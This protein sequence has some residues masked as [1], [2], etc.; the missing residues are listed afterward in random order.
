[1][2]DDDLVFQLR[3]W[4]TAQMARFAANDDGPSAGDHILQ[5]NIDLAP[6]TIARAKRRI[7]G[8]DG[9]SRRRFMAQK[10]STETLKMS[11]IPAWAVDPVPCHNDAGSPTTISAS[12]ASADVGI[13]DD[14]RWIDRAVSQMSRQHPVRAMVLREEFC[15]TGTHRMKAGRVERQYGGQLTVRQYRYELQRALDWMRGRLAA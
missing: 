4:G 5:R 3:R 12:R 10:T 15:G 6:R 8:R 1:M 14:L 13:P 7:V 9:E 2:A 11:I